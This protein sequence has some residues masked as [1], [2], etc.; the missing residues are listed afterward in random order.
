MRLSVTDEG[1]TAL[2]QYPQALSNLDWHMLPNVDWANTVVTDV[3]ITAVAQNWH[4][5]PKVCLTNI[6]VTD[7]GITVFV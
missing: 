7:E 4:A 2:A 3:S 5:Q 1:I 6:A